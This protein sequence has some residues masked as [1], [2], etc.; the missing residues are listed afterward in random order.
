[1]HEP[2]RMDKRKTVT[3][4]GRNPADLESLLFTGG[5]AF[6]YSSGLCQQLADV[7]SG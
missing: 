5:Q 7:A 6:S 1:M 4:Q 2:Q 3:A